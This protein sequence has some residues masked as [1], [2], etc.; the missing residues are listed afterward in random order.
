MLLINVLR[1]DQVDGIQVESRVRNEFRKAIVEFRFYLLGQLLV[2][3][4]QNEL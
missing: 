3:Y 4:F 1:N 2:I